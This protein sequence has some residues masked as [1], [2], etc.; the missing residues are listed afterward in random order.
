MLDLSLL[1]NAPIASDQWLWIVIALWIFAIGA[2]IGSF[3]N[4]VI[5]RLPSGLSIAHPP[6]HCPRCKHPIRIYDN[7]PVL[8][9]LL[10]RGKCRDC[11]AKFSPRYALVELVAGLLLV[12]IAA[13]TFEILIA[14]LGQSLATEHWLRAAGEIAL[15][16]TLLASLWSAALI[17]RDGHRPP[18]KLIATPLVV[19][20]VCAAI[21]PEPIAI[22]ATDGIPFRI[23]IPARL[24]GLFGATASAATV[25]LWLA[26]AT[27][28]SNKPAH[29]PAPAS[30]LIAWAAVV[31]LYVGWQ[32]A[33]AA[34]ALTAVLMALATF[35]FSRNGTQCAKRNVDWLSRYTIAVTL[36]LFTRSLWRVDE[37]RPLGDATLLAIATIIVSALIARAT[38]ANPIL[39]RK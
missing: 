23:A 17:A 10:L 16:A 7:I 38:S 19:G 3:L 18:W 20:L 32:L 33:I 31:G 5:Y 28:Q 30:W 15:L 14:L 39:T 2:S 25:S 1:G 9:Y 24:S 4:V 36:C 26:L 21:W 29:E 37:M 8:S 22:P 12:A 34:S 6:S 35:V 11:G 27:R 13:T